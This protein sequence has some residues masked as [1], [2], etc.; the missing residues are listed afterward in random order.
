MNISA[1]ARVGIDPLFYMKI[2]F[3]LNFWENRRYWLI[4]CHLLTRFCRYYLRVSFFYTGKVL[5]ALRM[6]KKCF[7]TFLADGKSLLPYLPKN[8][9]ALFKKEYFHNS[10]FPIFTFFKHPK[11]VFKWH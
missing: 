4:I 11:S 7:G 1:I 6:A 2:I 5:C 3:P 10:R 8:R 9:P